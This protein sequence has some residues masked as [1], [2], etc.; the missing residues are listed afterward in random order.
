MDG[1]ISIYLPAVAKYGLTYNITQWNVQGDQTHVS[2]PGY[3][4]VECRSNT[5]TSNLEA[6][7]VG[8]RDCNKYL[9]KLE[10]HFQSSLNIVFLGFDDVGLR[11]VEGRWDW[12]EFDSMDQSGKLY[13]RVKDGLDRPGGSAIGIMGSRAIFNLEYNGN[14]KEALLLHKAINRTNK[15]SRY[16]IAFGMMPP[17]CIGYR[18]WALFFVRAPMVGSFLYSNILYGCFGDFRFD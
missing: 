10:C 1:W 7:S 13:S 9:R 12:L 8:C 6:E 14:V 17:G 3:K 2:G 5:D 16:R 15:G 18:S 4:S 11:Y